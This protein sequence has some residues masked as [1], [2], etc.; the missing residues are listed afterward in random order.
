MYAT[1]EVTVINYVTK[2]TVQIFDMY[3]LTNIAT[4]LQVSIT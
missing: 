3:H 4:T 1:Y 2:S